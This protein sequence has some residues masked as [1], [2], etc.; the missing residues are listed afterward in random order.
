MKFLFSFFVL[1]IFSVLMFPPQAQA[2]VIRAKTVYV[3]PLELAIQ[4]RDENL[5]GVAQVEIPREEVGRIYWMITDD[6]GAVIWNETI[7]WKEDFEREEGVF[8]IPFF[9]D[10]GRYQRYG[11]FNVRF[12]IENPEKKVI[13]QGHRKIDVYRDRRQIRIDHLAIQHEE[14]ALE[15]R[16]VVYQDFAHEDQSFEFQPHITIYEYEAGGEIFFEEKGPFQRITGKEKKQIEFSTRLPQT[17]KLYVIRAH[18]LNRSGQPLTGELHETFVVEGNFAYTDFFNTDIKAFLSEGDTAS[19]HLGGIVRNPKIPLLVKIRSEQIHEGESVYTHRDQ[20]LVERFYFDEFEQHFD[21]PIKFPGAHHLKVKVDLLQE[22]ELLESKTFET[23]P[24]VPSLTDGYESAPTSHPLKNFLWG[25]LVFLFLMGGGVYL[26]QRK[27]SPRPPRMMLFWGLL[28]GLFYGG[29]VGAAPTVE[30]QFPTS[31][32]SVNPEASGDFANFKYLFFK[33]GI[34]EDG[35]TKINEDTRISISFWQDGEDSV[36]YTSKPQIITDLDYDIIQDTSDEIAVIRDFVKDGS[37]IKDAEYNFLIDFAGADFDQDPTE[38]G[39]DTQYYPFVRDDSPTFEDG[40]YNVEIYFINGTE[41]IIGGEGQD[42]NYPEIRIDSKPPTLSFKYDGETREDI[43]SGEYFTKDPVSLKINCE[44]DSDCFV[45]LSKSEFES[46][47]VAGNFCSDSEDYCDQPQGFVLCDQVGNCTNFSNNDNQINI[48]FYDPQPPTFE[49]FDLFKDNA[50]GYNVTTASRGE[51][52]ETFLM[53]IE[54][55]DG[56]EY[57]ET[58][59]DHPCDKDAEA[60]QVKYTNKEGVEYCETAEKPCALF[61]GN[62]VFE[63]GVGTLE[64]DGTCG[65]NTVTPTP[66]TDNDCCHWIVGEEGCLPYY[67]PPMPQHC[68]GGGHQCRETADIDLT[69]A[70]ACN[71][72]EFTEVPEDTYQSLK[73][74]G[75]CS[76][77]V[78]CEYKCQTGY[79]LVDGKCVEVAV[80]SCVTPPPW[81]EHPEFVLSEQGTPTDTDQPWRYVAHSGLFDP[82]GGCMFTCETG[83]TWDAEDGRCVAFTPPTGACADVPQTGNDKQYDTVNIPISAGE[84]Q[85]WTASNLKESLNYDD[86]G[87]VC[88]SDGENCEEGGSDLDEHLYMWTAAA[89]MYDPPNNDQPIAGICGRLSPGNWGLP[90]DNEWHQLEMAFAEGTCND[91]RNGEWDCAPSGTALQTGGDSDFE[92]VPVGHRLEDYVTLEDSGQAHYW[93]SDGSSGLGGDATAIYRALDTNESTVL[94][95]ETTTQNY[96]SVRCILRGSCA[97]DWPSGTGKRIYPGTPTQR[98]TEWTYNS[99]P[100]GL[101]ACYYMCDDTQ[102]YSWNGDDCVTCASTDS[103]PDNVDLHNLTYNADEAEQEWQYGGDSCSFVCASGYQWD[104]N[105]GSCI[106]IPSC[107]GSAPEASQGEILCQEDDQGLEIDTPYDLVGDEADS[108]TDEAKCEYYCNN[109]A[110]YY[111][112]GSSCT[113][114]DYENGY[115]WDFDTQTCEDPDGVCT[116][117]VPKGDDTQTR[118]QLC[119]GD[120]IGLSD[121]VERSLVE[122]CTETQKCEYVCQKAY[123]YEDGQCVLPQEQE[124]CSDDGYKI[125]YY[126]SHP[127]V[128][129]PQDADAP[130]WYE[131]IDCRNIHSDSICVEDE[132]P[133]DGSIDA[134]CTLP[135]DSVGDQKCHGN[136]RMKCQEVEYDDDKRNP[137]PEVKQWVELES[138]SGETD[139]CQEITSTQTQCSETCGDAGFDTNICGGDMAYGNLLDLHS[140]PHGISEETWWCGEDGTWQ[141]ND[142]PYYERTC[143]DTGVNEVQAFSQSDGSKN[144]ECLPGQTYCSPEG[145]SQNLKKCGSDYRWSVTVNCAKGCSK[146]G[147]DAYQGAHSPA[148]G[149]YGSNGYGFCW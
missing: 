123:V 39:E 42:G 73:N 120:G 80:P 46:Y 102:N 86:L 5:E 146:E 45:P 47:S 89:Q 48:D 28:I 61:Y 94:R 58:L 144:V 105:S 11:N 85:C 12:F 22:D 93:T 109:N 129:N 10:F 138:C 70:E 16:F 128:E 88:S 34:Y 9:Y 131:V 75:E 36:R 96:K 83:Y 136:T 13:A 43:L 98:N 122:N 30:W 141:Q 95:D 116:G 140:L 53:R 127:N 112:N 115:T 81:G 65:E 104:V 107:T 87:S 19:V 29:L 71:D 113:F 57:T 132:N 106:E 126:E 76:E 134:H 33:G 133:N 125:E 7:E 1:G 63:Y 69:Y 77:S 91:K 135:C 148:A 114:C 18:I 117:D 67:F 143:M 32:T 119:D 84:S 59:H 145:W 51:A 149:V 92:A 110:Y 56:R 124:K 139:Q 6:L 60:N 52:H 2:Q 14:G 20:R 49:G 25:G 90:T 121:N 103:L 15:G 66:D 64:D 37:T 142:L 100:D 78:K 35:E 17:P 97:S 101:S 21:I 3:S 4:T 68:H 108:C 31:T 99:S 44:D 54:A 55:K 79:T 130:A 82:T 62:G 137:D 118:T 8:Y 147:G 27:K 72:N 41:V 50:S 74:E 38:E 40:V 23:T 24:Y 111:Y 26:L